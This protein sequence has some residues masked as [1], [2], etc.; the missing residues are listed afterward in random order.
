MEDVTVC[1]YIFQNNNHISLCITFQLIWENILLKNM[2]FHKLSREVIKFQLLCDCFHHTGE[3]A[4][5]NRFISCL[6]DSQE[7]GSA[8]ILKFHP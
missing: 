6:E 4:K 8:R 7:L 2:N 1:N 3:K 5:A